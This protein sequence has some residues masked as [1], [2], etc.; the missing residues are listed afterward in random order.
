MTELIL[1]LAAGAP[2]IIL[3]ALTV[4]NILEVFDGYWNAGGFLRMLRDRALEGSD[5]KAEM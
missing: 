2:L 5:R 3:G 1:L 4:F